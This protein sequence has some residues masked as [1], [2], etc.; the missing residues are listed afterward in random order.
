MRLRIALARSPHD[1]VA[2]NTSRNQIVH[3]AIDYL[4]R[5]I[6]CRASAGTRK[7]NTSRTRSW[8]KKS[9]TNL[10]NS[11]SSILKRSLAHDAPVFQKRSVAPKYNSA[12]MR[13]MTN[14]AK[15]KLRKKMIFSR[16]MTPLFTS[17]TPDQSQTLCQVDSLKR[18]RL[19]QGFGVPR[20][21]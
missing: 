20:K 16:S 8:M 4:F 11:F 18:C 3:D 12:K 7:K 1:S 21:R 13:P 5:A 17:A 14:A 19:R 15:K 9:N 10:P 6:Q 2:T